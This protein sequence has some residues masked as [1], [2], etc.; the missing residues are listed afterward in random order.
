MFKSRLKK[1]VAAFTLIELLV[2]IAIIA[3][4]I[5]LLLPAV[6][7][8]REAATRLRCTNNLKQIGLASHGF[9]DTNTYIVPTWLG[10]NALDPDGWASWAVLLLPHL[11]QESIYKKW[12]L[13]RPASYQSPDAYQT[14][15]NAYLCPGRPDSV[16]STGDFV[17]Q[18]AGVTPGGALS[19]YAANF[20]THAS[21]SNSLGA[22]VPLRAMGATTTTD[23]AGKPIL[24]SDWKGQVNFG[25]IGDG[26]SNTVF[27]GEKHIR[28]NSLRGRNEDRSIFG[29]VNN[30]VR[31]M[32]GASSVNTDQRPLMPPAAQSPAL[33]N[34]SFGG[35]HSGICQFVFGDGSVK[36]VSTNATMN[37]LTALATRDSGEII[38]EDY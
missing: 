1:S 27:F 7:K 9:H 31:R 24:K 19:D 28:P 18:T 36:S 21:G 33:A 12:D 4:L 35:P 14:V 29:G 34:S 17:N 32:L 10:S 13:L 25:S 2:V 5:G 20:G 11:E 16:L 6:Q 3:I 37:T 8:V 26:L 38:S 23:A 15:V 22:I 30:A